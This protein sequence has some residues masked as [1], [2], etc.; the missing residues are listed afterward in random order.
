MHERAIRTGVIAK[1]TNEN[2][3]G[4]PNYFQSQRARS[5]ISNQEE[6]EGKKQLLKAD[7]KP[8]QPSKNSKKQKKHTARNRSRHADVHMNSEGDE[9]DY[10][11]EENESE[12]NRTVH[13]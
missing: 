13:Y 1:S 6:K 9:I 10:N 3:L 8:E 2:N 4:F 5:K 7:K 12:D 11:L